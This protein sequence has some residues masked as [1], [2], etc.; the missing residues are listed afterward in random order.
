M[1]IAANKRPLA[2]TLLALG[3]L[4]PASV[5]IAETRDFGGYAER[6]KGAGDKIPPQC[7]V[8]APTA[9]EADFA[10]KWN[11]V[12]D[13]PENTPPEKMRSRFWIRRSADTRWRL[14][15]TFLGFPAAVTVDRSIL[16]IAPDA[17]FKSG[18]PLALRVEAWD[19]AGNATF[20]P[21]MTISGQDN[22]LDTCSLQIVTVATESTGDT[23][24]APSLTVAL[25]DSAVATSDLGQEQIQIATT[26]PAEAATCEIGALCS[27]DDELTF[28]ITLTLGDDGQASGTL[29]VIPSALRVDLAGPIQ[30]TDSV[31]RSANLSGTTEIDGQ[32]A[33]VTL[34]CA[35]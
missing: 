9:A 7:Q 11:C 2:V 12:D 14:V 32:E 28:D 26:A 10:V 29:L 18:L 22:S 17:E 8:N 25:N 23:T 4:A 3:L 15:D 31:L 27:D 33:N 35:Q 1:I 30:L 20:S 6:W 5:A 13:N 21:T 24:G 34:S 19:V 16:G